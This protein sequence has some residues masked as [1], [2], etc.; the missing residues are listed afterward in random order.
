MIAVLENGLTKAELTGARD[1]TYSHWHR[2]HQSEHPSA[3]CTYS[4]IDGLEYCSDCG[5]PLLL[6]ETAIG[7]E[8][9]KKGHKPLFRLAERADVPA[10]LV[11]Y[12]LGDLRWCDRCQREFHSVDKL[13]VRDVWPIRTDTTA[14]TPDEWADDIE[15]IHAEHQCTI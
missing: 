3:A 6:V 7:D 14:F 8:S 9:T 1:L 15:R 12:V 10:V 2:G 4:D 5:A 11:F 13:W